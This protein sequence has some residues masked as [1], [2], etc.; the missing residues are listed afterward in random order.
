[1]IADLFDQTISFQ[2]LINIFFIA[3]RI[4]ISMYLLR[5]TLYGI[6]PIRFFNTMI[7]FLKEHYGSQCNHTM[8]VP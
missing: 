3:Y 8:Y 1:M 2:L 7:L 4:K 6:D 5:E